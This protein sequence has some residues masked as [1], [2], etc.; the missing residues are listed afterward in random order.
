MGTKMV[1]RP[2]RAPYKS[3]EAPRNTDTVLSIIIPTLNAADVLRPTLEA[4]SAARQLPHEIIVADAGSIDDTPL[5]AVSGGA[6]LLQT[7]R[8]RGHQLAAGAAAA[9][10]DW[11]LFLHADTQP[12]AGWTQPVWAFMADP[13]NRFHAGYFR[14]ALNDPARAARLVE[15]VVRLRGRLLGLPYGDQGLLIGRTF[16]D[17][18]GGHKRLPL[19]ED[20]DIVRRI[21]RNRL[22][23]IAATAVTSA[24]KYRRDGYLLRPIRNLFMLGLYTVGVSPRYLRTLYH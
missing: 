8:G 3:Y 7:Q 6:I 5:I 11:F 18:L 23:P 24:D 19:M 13:V 15:R 21:G 16:Y 2:A 4:L 20:V 17:K 12:Q 22:R 1:S 14:F 9:A 10:G